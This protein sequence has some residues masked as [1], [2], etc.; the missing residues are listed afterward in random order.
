MIDS[1]KQHPCAGA[2]GNKAPVRG[3]PE[4]DEKNLRINRNQAYISALGK[5]VCSISIKLY[6][7]FYSDLYS[8]NMY[9]EFSDLLKRVTVQLDDDLHTRVKVVSALTSESMND[10]FVQAIKDYLDKLDEQKKP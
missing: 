10:M 4:F 8:S 6:L 2:R 5:N 7:Q 3:Q 1:Y 9:D